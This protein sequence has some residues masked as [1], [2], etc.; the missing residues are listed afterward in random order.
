M[1]ESII[2]RNFRPRATA[3]GRTGATG[4]RPSHVP[5]ARAEPLRRG[6]ALRTTV[7]TG[8]A[9]TRP[10]AL[11]V[12]LGAGHG[13]IVGACAGEPFWCQ[14]TVSN[15][16]RR[17]VTAVV[18]GPVS[19][20]GGVHR[21]AA[22]KSTGGRHRRRRTAPPLGRAPMLPDRARSRRTFAAARASGALGPFARRV[23]PCRADVTPA[24]SHRGHTSRALGIGDAR[25]S[26]RLA[27]KGERAAPRA[28]FDEA[29]NAFVLAPVRASS[30]RRAR[31]AGYTGL[32]PSRGDR[33][34]RGPFHQS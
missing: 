30:E 3:A 21:R 17:A 13:R 28:P 25:D 32:P 34:P 10:A 15:S 2:R 24:T 27:A 6:R 23:T 26:N 9:P 33:T 18:G 11:V 22:A 4:R 20:D 14:S 5:R 29:T 8:P 7:P 31:G 12:G 16:A 1:A 19:H